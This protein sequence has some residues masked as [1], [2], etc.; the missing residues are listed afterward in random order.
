MARR[1]GQRLG[2]VGGL[3]VS[4]DYSAQLRVACSQELKDRLADEA[5][6]NRENASDT[7]RRL[8]AER[9]DQLD[10]DRR[11]PVKLSDA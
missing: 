11:V 6:L 10:R 4:H 3:A 2:E 5:H 7:I 8:L 9:L 1:A